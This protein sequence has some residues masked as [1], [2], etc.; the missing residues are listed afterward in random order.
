MPANTRGKPVSTDFASQFEPFTRLARLYEKSGITAEER[1]IPYHMSD[2]FNRLNDLLNNDHEG[3]INYV[4][5]PWINEVVRSQ[6]SSNPAIVKAMNDSEVFKAMQPEQKEAFTKE[7]TELVVEQKW[8]DPLRFLK[9][10]IGHKYRLAGF[11][12]RRLYSGGGLADAYLTLGVQ[13]EEKKQYYAS[14]YGKGQ[15]I[16][17][18]HEDAPSIYITGE[19]GAGKTNGAHDL[20]EE[21]I[22]NQYWVYTN[23]PIVSDYGHVLLTRHYSDLYID[24]PEMPS[25]LRALLWARKHRIPSGSYLVYDEGGRG[26]ASKSTTLEGETLR[27]HLQI[28]R[29]YGSGFVQ[30]GV[31]RMQARMEAEG[32]LDYLIEAKKQETG[33]MNPKTK[34]P[35]YRYYWDIATRGPTKTTLHEYVYNIPLTSLKL[36]YANDLRLPY[37]LDMDMLSLEQFE[38]AVDFV[39]TP[40]EQLI[41]DTRNYVRRTVRPELVGAPIYGEEEDDEQ[42][43][44][45]KEKETL[46]VAMET[47][48]K[49][50]DLAIP[51][52][53][54]E[55]I[56]ELRKAGTS[57]VQIS[58]EFNIPLP[59]ITKICKQYGWL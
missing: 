37:P 14:W 18:S 49:R 47:A 38:K 40:L 25:I 20:I 5:R 29:H 57:M 35:V 59:V 17:I 46:H 9:D 8:E 48:V 30:L 39:T 24:T 56:G 2:S 26:A 28:R 4:A 53:Q 21:M 13:R 45:E 19:P 6:M 31:Q 51:Q 50:E 43:E 1:M 55:A 33:K 44:K 16:R 3:F 22:A 42:V 41:V 15:I 7:L 32:L 52:D 34:Q 27:A 12:E 54:I 58:R 11:Y 10:K 36:N 23:M